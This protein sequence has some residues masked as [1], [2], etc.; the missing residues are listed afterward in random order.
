MSK[1]ETV[2]VS[3]IVEFEA[4]CT[5]FGLSGTYFRGQVNDYPKVLPSLFRPGA[6]S[7]ESLADLIGNL[8]VSCYGILDWQS[9]REEQQQEFADSFNPIGPIVDLFPYGS[10]LPEPPLS[11]EDIPFKLSWF[12]YDI[13]EFKDRLKESFKRKTSDHS[14]ALLQH[15]GVPSRGL[16]VT[17]DPLVA[18]W[19]ATNA[20]VSNPDKTAQFSPTD[21]TNRVVYVFKNPPMTIVNLQLIASAAE[22][23][24]EGVPEIPYFGLRGIRQKGLLLLGATREKPD[25]REYVSAMIHLKPGNW[26]EGVLKSRGYEYKRLIPPPAEDRFYEALLREQKAVKSQ[27]EK[28]VRHII[29]Y[30]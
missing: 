5:R 9:M 4:A 17:D 2:D 28:V 1:V 25:L 12:N 23:G 18:L 20:F 21:G 6:A 10:K 7:D 19:F 8:Y 13:D 15:Y 16:D 27:Y 22:I 11:R 14:D 30:V 26:S 24:F 29:Q 3:N